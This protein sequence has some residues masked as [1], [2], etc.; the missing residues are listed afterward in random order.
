MAGGGCV[1]KFKNC[2]ALGAMERL[3]LVMDA[4]HQLDADPAVKILPA[5]YREA[6]DLDGALL[7]AIE[8]AEAGYMAIGD[9]IEADNP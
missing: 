2:Q 6:G 9:R 8:R 5:R 7:K 4:F 1:K 3:S